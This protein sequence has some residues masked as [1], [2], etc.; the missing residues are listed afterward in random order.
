MGHVNAPMLLGTL[1]VVEMA[2][3]AL[4]LPHG[5]GGALAAFSYLAGEVKG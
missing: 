1:S 2:F 4:R 5:R 3:E